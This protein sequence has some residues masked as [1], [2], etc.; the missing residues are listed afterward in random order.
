MSGSGLLGGLFGFAQ[1]WMEQK[2]AQQ[3]HKNRLEELKLE[4]ELGIQTLELEAQAK[5]A[6]AEIEAK[7]KTQV[8]EQQTFQQSY[9][10][11]AALHTGTSQWVVNGRAAT[12][13]LLTWLV[14]VSTLIIG[15]Y[16]AF[17]YEGETNHY[18]NT[19]SA[20][21]TTA[22]GWWFARRGK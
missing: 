12:R 10:H 20:F 17:T 19:L 1:S 14:V 7:A 16:L 11:D 5:Q 8:A 21:A 6:I 18:F 13:F 2:K 3:E 22:F 15:G 9:I 4:A